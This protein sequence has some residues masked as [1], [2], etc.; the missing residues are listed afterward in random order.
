MKT[1]YC[2]VFFEIK[3]VRRRSYVSAVK[4]HGQTIFL[5]GDFIQ[6]KISYLELFF[7]DNRFLRHYG[8]HE[9]AVHFK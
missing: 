4:L 5:F 9:A 6:M 8:M 1:N 2:E 3:F 7:D